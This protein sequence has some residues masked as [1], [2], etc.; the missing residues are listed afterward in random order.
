MMGRLKINRSGVALGATDNPHMEEWTIMIDPE[1]HVLFYTDGLTE[2]FNYEGD[3]FGDDGLL[4]AIQ[5]NHCT[6]ASELLM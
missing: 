6:S 2:S 3:F 4:K 5:S 1:D